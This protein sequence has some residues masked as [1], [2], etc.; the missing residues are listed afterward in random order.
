MTSSND[1][2]VDYQPFIPS[3]WMQILTDTPIL[4]ARSEIIDLDAKFIEYLESDGLYLEET[5]Y[6]SQFSDSDRSST[7]SD[8]KE[9]GDILSF[10]PS[11]TFP[12]VHR[13]IENVLKGLGGCVVPKV[14]WTVPKVEL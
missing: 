13:K 14:N 9:D 12:E 4:G 10:K 6:N 8:P 3:Y 7:E 5:Q 1:Q 11:D 2:A